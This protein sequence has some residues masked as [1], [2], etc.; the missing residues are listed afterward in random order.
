MQ[1][2]ASPLARLVLF[3]VCLA[4]AA[5]LVA[6]AHYALIGLP[7]ESRHPPANIATDMKCNNDCYRQYPYRACNEEC[8]GK[9][10]GD[11]IGQI[12]CLQWCDTNV[13]KPY[14]AC[15]EQNC[16]MD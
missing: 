14:Y 9:H 1:I 2:P 8:Y 6:A 12:F 7:D 10:P 16:V 15:V 11:V 13:L 4:I 5:S 3:I